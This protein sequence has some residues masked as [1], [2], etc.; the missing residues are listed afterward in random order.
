VLAASQTHPKAD[1]TAAVPGKANARGYERS[2][3][4]PRHTVTSH[5]S[6]SISDYNYFG[7]LPGHILWF[8][9][10]RLARTEWA[11]IPAEFGGPS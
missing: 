3:P 10:V 7:R 9:W 2:P 6:E 1:A 8:P 5:D 4:G 11:P